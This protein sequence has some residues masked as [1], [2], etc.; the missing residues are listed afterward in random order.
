MTT[1][2]NTPSGSANG[3]GGSSGT[4]IGVILLIIVLLLLFF[5]GFP[6]LRG[7]RQQPTSTSNPTS[8][9]APVAV[10]SSIDVNVNTPKQ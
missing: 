8:N 5:Y 7:S 4:I 3:D 9:S 6:L 10:P 1:I 2:V